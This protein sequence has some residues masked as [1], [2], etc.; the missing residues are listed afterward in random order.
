MFH[1]CVLQ[2]AC[3]S[4]CAFSVCGAVPRHY[5]V[6]DNMS[7]V[8]VKLQLTHRGTR[9]I[10]NSRVSSAYRHLDNSD[11]SFMQLS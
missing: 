7:R 2:F 3:N 6:S 4:L 11:Y 5:Q 1:E 10:F 8:C 9:I